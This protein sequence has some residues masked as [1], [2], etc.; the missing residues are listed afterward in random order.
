MKKIILVLLLILLLTGC[1]S[2]TP[3]PVVAPV[4]SEFTL[5]TNQTATIANTELTIRLIGVGGDQRCPSQI[6]CAVSGPVSLSLSAQVGNQ[7]PAN[8]DLQV[9]TGN[10]GRAPD[11]QFQGI[12]DRTT[13]A[14]YVIRVVGVLP[15]PAKSFN[16]IKDSV[17]R[18]TLIVSK[19]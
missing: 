2:A 16:E 17:Y 3:A 5:A 8:I 10:D 7:A 13:Y 19:P 9:F 6:E 4:G 1:G 14:G 11:I 15:Y 18:V 12:Q